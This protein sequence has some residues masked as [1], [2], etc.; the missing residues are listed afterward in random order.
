MA[1]DEVVEEVDGFEVGDLVVLLGGVVADQDL[2]R[3]DLVSND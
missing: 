1:A 2:E 3:I